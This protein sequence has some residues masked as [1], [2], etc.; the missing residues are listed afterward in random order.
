[1][2]QIILNIGDIVVCRGPAVL[3]TLLG[4]CVSVCLWDESTGIGGMNHYL[5]P[6]NTSDETPPH[7]C[8]PY[9]I[10]MLVTRMRKAG[11]DI[12]SAKAKLFGGGAVVPTLKDTVHVGNENVA[13]A[14]MELER[15][16]IPV[17]NEYLCGDA[18]LKVRFEPHTGRA[19]IKKL[20]SF[21]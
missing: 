7:Y 21:A 3:E 9:S 10:N 8:G 18:G 4:S 2:K 12:F 1:M 5:L 17:I 19:F 6:Y 16:G 20:E 11:A 15:L 14:R 13:V